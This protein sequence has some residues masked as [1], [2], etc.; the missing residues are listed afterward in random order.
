MGT[1]TIVFFF[2]FPLD[3]DNFNVRIHHCYDVIFLLA[4]N[5]FVEKEP[6]TNAHTYVSFWWFLIA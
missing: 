3:H 5:Y 4:D 1:C 6:Y 2:L